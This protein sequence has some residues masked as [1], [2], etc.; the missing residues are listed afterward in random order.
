MEKLEDLV[1]ET[2]EWNHGKGVDISAWISAEG[3]YNLALG[4]TSFFWPKFVEFEDYILYEG[5]KEENVRAFEAMTGSSKK[6]VESVLNHIHL[7]DLHNDKDDKI[8]E[9][10]IIY[11][12]EVL[13]EIYEAKLAWQFPSKPCVVKFYKP[14]SPETIE[15]YQITFWQVKHDADT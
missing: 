13:K 11:L 14:Q 2:K 10:K 9:A 7:S 3:N 5:V 4:Y 6:A 12:G 15:D 1:E 8:S